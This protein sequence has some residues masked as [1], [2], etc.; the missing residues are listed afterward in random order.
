MSFFLYNNASGC[1]P[2]HLGRIWF[3]ATGTEIEC[4]GLK[5]AWHIHSYRI[6]LT[7]THATCQPKFPESRKI[8]SAVLSYPI[9]RNICIYPVL[10]SFSTFLVQTHERQNSG[11]RP[12]NLVSI[13]FLCNWRRIQIQD[14][15]VVALLIKALNDTLHTHILQNFFVK[16]PRKKP[17]LF[18]LDSLDGCAGIDFLIAHAY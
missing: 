16:L 2:H 18:L 1:W 8:L 6:A 7:I 9:S 10:L 5:V 13:F 14:I 12:H 15:N 4:S 3:D 11:Y 17:P